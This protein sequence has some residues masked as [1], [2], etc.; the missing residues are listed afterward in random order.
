[1]HGIFLTIEGPDGVGKTT[2][3]NQLAC[4]LRDRGYKVTLTRE[5][6]GTYL[7][8][9]I[10]ELL[11]DPDNKIVPE[12]ETLLYAAARAQHVNEVIL[13]AL[14]NGRIV[15]CDRFIDS[16]IAYQG[17]GRQVP[18]QQIFNANRAATKELEPDLTILLDLDVE[19]C[20]QRTIAGNTRLD[21]ME[22]EKIEFHWKVRQGFLEQARLY[23]DRIFLIPASG[24]IQETFTKIKNCVLGYLKKIQVI[25]VHQ[26]EKNVRT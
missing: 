5:P 14:N 26:G 9:K 25:D 13:P 23:P 24:T 18:L 22:K 15:I 4:F 17:Y 6:G 21:R 8:E 10:R 20:I 2:Q 12:A 1:M 19:V 16:S 3:A 11:L 7:A